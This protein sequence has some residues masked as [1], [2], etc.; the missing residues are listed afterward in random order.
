MAE[1]KGITPAEIR[2]ALIERG[3]AAVL[4]ITSWSTLKRQSIHLKKQMRAAEPGSRRCLRRWR[5]GSSTSMASMA[6]L[7]GFRALRLSRQGGYRHEDEVSP[8]PRAA[9]SRPCGAR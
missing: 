4:R 8:R 6:A 7:Y 5:S 9:L 3:V 1:R 2:A